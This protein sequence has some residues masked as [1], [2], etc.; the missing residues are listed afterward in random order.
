MFCTYGTNTPLRFT[1]LSS[2]F[3]LSY[4]IVVLWILSVDDNG[5]ILRLSATIVFLH[6]A[7]LG[8]TLFDN[9]SYFLNNRIVSATSNT[10]IIVFD[11]SIY[12]YD[13]HFVFLCR[14]NART[15]KYGNVE[16][17]PSKWTNINKNYTRVNL[18]E[19]FMFHQ[20]RLYAL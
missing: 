9:D 1:A 2:E 6:S 18:A 3:V 15:W 10:T 5:N 20:V 13:D 14:H 11:N 17:S 8:G 7:L 16:T 4:S 12:Y 19:R